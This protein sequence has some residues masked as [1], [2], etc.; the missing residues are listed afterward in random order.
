MK[1]TVKSI[2]LTSL[3][4][5][6][7]IAVGQLTTIPASTPCGCDGGLTYS[8][9]QGSATFFTFTDLQGNNIAN[10]GSANG[11]LNLTN[12]C[13]GVY[14]I[15]ATTAANTYSQYVQIVNAIAPMPPIA[16]TDICSTSPNTNLNNSIAGL[17]PGG[18]WT[19]PNGNIFNGIYN[20]ST[21]SSGFYT[22][23][24]DNAGCV[25]TT[26]VLVNEIQNANA[27]IQTTYL[28][29]DSYAAFNMIDFLE[30]NP[31]PGG[32]WLTSGGTPMDG[33]YNPATMSSGLFVYAI[34]NV[35]GC[36]AVFTTM[37][38]DERITPNAGTSSSL[39]VCNGAPAFNL[40]DQIPGNPMPGGFWFRPNGTPFN[41][42]FNPAIDP[43]GN[44]RYVVTANAPCLDAESTITINFSNTDPSG[45]SNQLD[46]CSSQQAFDM[47]SALGGSPIAGGIWTNTNGQTISGTFNPAVNNSGV[48]SYY[49]PNVGCNSQG[50]QLTITEFNSPNA[51]QD[52]ITELCTSPIPVD[53]FTLLINENPGGIFENNNGTAI[54]NII[55]I[56][57]TQLFQAEYI[58][59][60]SVCPADTASIIIGVVAPPFSPNDL[61]YEVCANSGLLNLN[62]LYQDVVFPQWFDLNGT[63]IPAQFDPASGST[64]LTIVSQSQNAC[65]DENANLDIL[66]AQPAFIDQSINEIFCTTEFPIDLNNFLAASIISA[67]EWYDANN[68]LI[69]NTV[70]N[71]NAGNYNYQYI[72]ENNGPCAASVISVG[73]QVFE[74]AEAG[75]GSNIIVCESE[76]NFSLENLLSS[77][78]QNG[79]IWYNAGVPII[80]QNYSLVGNVIDVLT[81]EVSGNLGCAPDAAQFII[82]VHAQVNAQAG[83][84]VSLCFGEINVQIGS[85]PIPNLNYSWVPSALLSNAQVANPVIT[86]NGLSNENQGIVFTLTVSDG[87]CEATDEVLVTILEIPIVSINALTEI[88]L[89]EEV[90]YTVD[91]SLICAWSPSN[92]FVNPSENDPTIAP[93]TSTN[94]SVLVENDNGC[95]ATSS[96]EIIVRPVP[97]IDFEITPSADCAPVMVEDTWNSAVGLDYAIQWNGGNG[98]DDSGIDYLFN[99]TSPGS[100][101][102]EL[103]VAN[104]FGCISDSIYEDAVVVYP[105]P[106]ADF[107]YSPD[108]PS[109]I[110]N[111]VQFK[112]ES[113]DVASFEWYIDDALIGSEEILMHEFPSDRSGDYTVCLRVENEFGC[114]AT[115]CEYVEIQNDFTFYAPNAFTPDGDGLNDFFVP[116][117]LGFDLST[118]SLKIFDRWGT[119]VFS[120]NDASEPWI[121]N[122]RNGD[123]YAQQGIYNWIVEVKV[124]R[125]A[126]FKTFKGSV[127]LVR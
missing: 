11:I 84:D 72:S 31:D 51:G 26:G 36:N 127:L 102:I 110:N 73:L 76:Q 118:Y 42:V 79:G 24:F 75:D 28:I 106:I 4:L 82:D 114:E 109:I 9:E 68:L 7:L 55:N 64:T 94:V 48:F 33:V 25:Q 12:L 123:Y 19:M 101:D 32:Q 54:S 111:A 120:T 10:L 71:L 126:D 15:E 22:Y 113:E 1:F 93:L 18:I 8:P 91:P 119:L 21:L 66:V 112:N 69:Q 85:L 6:T 3:L 74:A 30:G 117:L 88:C 61:V 100:Y 23:T 62:D 104:E 87:V 80:P 97:E 83:D 121:G 65:P 38:I 13:E 63:Q 43:A 27:G 41:G 49:F 107:N 5:N 50:A 52:V 45:T 35:P 125:L 20:P 53:L 70:V 115:H 57:S 67:G 14:F 116:Q 29:C 59:S 78:A 96:G 47:L 81:Y 34:D 95:T 77:N 16:E 56:S 46:V 99:Y 44:Y 108:P 89:G 58:V 122:V 86:L 60:S 2:I 124:D 103:R 98:D 37:F 17:P 105:N 40:F 90:N 92:L 39:I